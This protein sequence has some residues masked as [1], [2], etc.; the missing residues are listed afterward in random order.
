M[1]CE[2]SDIP[3][4]QGEQNISKKDCIWPKRKESRSKGF[5]PRVGLED[6]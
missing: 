3:G 2:I 4:L 5:Q 1:S 6:Q